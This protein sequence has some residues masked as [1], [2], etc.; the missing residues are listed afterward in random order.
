VLKLLFGTALNAD[1]VQVSH[2]VNSLQ[3]RKED[4]IHDAQTQSK[5]SRKIDRRIRANGKTL[6]Q[7]ILL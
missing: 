4:L 6:A 3:E 2:R 5:M 7:M 1:L